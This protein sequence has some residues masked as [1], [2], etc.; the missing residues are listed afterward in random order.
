MSETILREKYG[1]QLA[2]KMADK[3]DPAEAKAI[4]A[5]LT[6]CEDILG[7]SFQRHAIPLPFHDK[8]A[9]LRAV[10]FTDMDEQLAQLPRAKR[11][12]VNKNKGVIQL[13]LADK[14][15]RGLKVELTPDM[16]QTVAAHLIR[17]SGEL[18]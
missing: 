2:V 11:L 14:K 9:D 8:V 10:A 12:Q 3:V 16:A 1:I 7:D 5:W 18:S 4:Q 15:E 17:M 6:E 13:G